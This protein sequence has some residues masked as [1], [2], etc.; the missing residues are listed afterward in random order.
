MNYTHVVI[1]QSQGNSYT[2]TTHP[3]WEQI[4]AS[5]AGHT[6]TPQVLVV[7]FSTDELLSSEMADMLWQALPGIWFLRSNI[8]G[9]EQREG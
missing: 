4:H 8:D 3:I 9:S 2:F 6:W 1:A 7:T 5:V